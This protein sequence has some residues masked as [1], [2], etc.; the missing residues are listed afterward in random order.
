[1]VLGLTE[2]VRFCTEKKEPGLSTDYPADVDDL[3]GHAM[4]TFM[5]WS[6]KLGT[7]VVFGGASASFRINPEE[8]T[9]SNSVKLN[10]LD[11]IED[12][13]REHAKAM[14][15]I[16]QKMAQVGRG[17]T[18]WSTF[19]AENVLFVQKPMTDP[20]E[21]DVYGFPQLTELYLQACVLRN[22]VSFVAKKGG[23]LANFKCKCRCFVLKNCLKACMDLSFSIFSSVYIIL[24]F[25][26]CRCRSDESRCSS[27]VGSV[28][29]TVASSSA[30][31]D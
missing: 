17:G 3:L 5:T 21:C 10:D 12:P 4:K 23:L 9:A 25:S 8:W 19:T 26:G 30:D 7:P 14:A 15:E 2:D 11:T 27:N 29:G 31:V 18:P 22:T 20:Y 6:K 1:V 16:Y 13:L 28:V 24:F